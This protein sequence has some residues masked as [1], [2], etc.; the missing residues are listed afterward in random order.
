MKKILSLLLVTVPFLSLA[1]TTEDV[2][3]ADLLA[4]EGVIVDQSAN[5][6]AYRIDDFVLRQEVV[7]MAL[8]TANIELPENY[9][10]QGYFTDATFAASHLDSWVC[11]AFEVAADNTYVTRA[12]TTTRPKD[13]V[14]RAEAL[15]IVVKAGNISVN[16]AN[17]SGNDFAVKGYADWQTKL[18]VSLPDCRIY[19]DGKSCEDGAS[20][21]KAV[22]S[23]RPNDRATRADVFKFIM[24]TPRFQA[25]QS[26]LCLALVDGWE[27]DGS[28]ED[29]ILWLEQLLS[30]CPNI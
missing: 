5:P 14:T 17:Y 24:Y 10:C 30:A 26:E 3:R 18:L 29:S 22:G 9:S 4:R 23:F 19:N 28:I 15:A 25:L 27:M 8:R 16:E 13:Y 12:N 11:R 20:I 1:Y 7:G 2:T 21:N 6:S